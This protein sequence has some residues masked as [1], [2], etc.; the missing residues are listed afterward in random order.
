[1]TYL[2]ELADLFLLILIFQFLLVGLMSSRNT[3]N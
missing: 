1:M 3:K 2:K